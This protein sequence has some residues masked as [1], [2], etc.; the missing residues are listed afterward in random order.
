MGERVRLKE[1]FELDKKE[2]KKCKSTDSKTVVCTLRR[3]Q[4]PIITFIMN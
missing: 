4:N 2:E 1:N 3:K